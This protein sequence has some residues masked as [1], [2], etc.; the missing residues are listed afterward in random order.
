M[1]IPDIKFGNC[2]G[3]SR[4]DRSAVGSLAVRVGYRFTLQ[5]SHGKLM[6]GGEATRSLRSHNAASGQTFCHCRC[7]RVQFQDVVDTADDPIAD[8]ASHQFARSG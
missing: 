2:L 7:D 1:D 4:D 3:R 8:G 5:D 6:V